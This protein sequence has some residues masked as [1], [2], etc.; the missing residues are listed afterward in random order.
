MDDRA[1]IAVSTSNRSKVGELFPEL[2]LMAGYQ[3]QYVADWV[4]DKTR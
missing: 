1:L 2:P 4:G 3:C